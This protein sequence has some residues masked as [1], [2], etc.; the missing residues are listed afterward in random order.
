MT[1]VDVGQPMVVGATVQPDAALRMEFGTGV[2]AHEEAVAPEEVMRF[3][4]EG[5]VSGH[6]RQAHA[7]VADRP[8]GLEF[9]PD[10]V[11]LPLTAQHGEQLAVVS[12]TLAQHAGS[13]IGIRDLLGAQPF[14]AI[15]AMPIAL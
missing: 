11:E 12:K 1:R 7:P 5:I 13:G 15:M 4:G 3:D 8:G 9:A 6:R 14:A 10:H 2:V